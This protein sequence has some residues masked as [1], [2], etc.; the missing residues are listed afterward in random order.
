MGIKQPPQPTILNSEYITSGFLVGK[1]W[2]DPDLY[3]AVPLM[4]SK[5]KLAIIYHGHQIKTCQNEESAR[6]FIQEHKKK[7]KK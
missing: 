6:K 4:S 1:S 3:A 7:N 2:E 5:T